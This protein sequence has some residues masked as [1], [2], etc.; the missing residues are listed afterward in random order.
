MRPN[1]E[2]RIAKA[3]KKRKC[4]WYFGNRIPIPLQKLLNDFDCHKKL[5]ITVA[6]VH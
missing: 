3:E 1:Y 4:I 2:T 5:K 6:S